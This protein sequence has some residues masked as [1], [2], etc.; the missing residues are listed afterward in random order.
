MR[1]LSILITLLAAT[2][3]GCASQGGAL[4]VCDGKHLRPGNS[5]GSVLE[6][7][8]SAAASATSAAPAEAFPS[9]GQ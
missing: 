3:G 7:S 1:T 2:S 4:P 5:H 9:C 6:P 8:T